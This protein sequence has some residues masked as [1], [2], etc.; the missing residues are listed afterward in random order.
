MENLKKAGI[1]IIL[2]LVAFGAGRFASPTKVVTK[3][4]EKVVNK[5]VVKWKTKTVIEETKNKEII[6]TKTVKP[7]GTVVETKR[8]VDKGTVSKDSS[9]DSQTEKESSKSKITVEVKEKSPPSWTIS[10]LARYKD[11]GVD[12]GASAYKRVLGPVGV[13]VFG[14]QKGEIGVSMG[15]SF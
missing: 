13:G 1:V 12:F 8:I 3:V 14:I 6:I 2:M 10:G 11:G 4:E 5:E 9:K 7:D 15:F